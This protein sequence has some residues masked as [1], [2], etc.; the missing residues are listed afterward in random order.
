[1]AKLS[2]TSPGDQLLSFDRGLHDNYRSTVYCCQNFRI[3]PGA[4]H[5]EFTDFLLLNARR[6][7]AFVTAYNPY[8]VRQ[9]SLVEN[10]ARHARLTAELTSR[11]LPFLPASAR[12]TA[13]RWPVEDGVFVLDASLGEMLA[14]GRHYGQN[15]ILWGEVGELPGVLWCPSVIAF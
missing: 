10:Q 11:H 4:A 1:M 12:D 2:K 7:F 3:R 15:A 8:S 13:D 14:I 6:S 5:P 9:L